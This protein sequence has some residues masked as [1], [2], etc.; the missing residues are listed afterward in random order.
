MNKPIPFFC[1]ILFI[2]T[3]FTLSGQSL[4]LPISM[5]V[6]GVEIKGSLLLADSTI[7]TPVVLIIA[8]SGPTDRDGNNVMMKNN[9]LKFLAEGLLVHG[10][11]SVRYDKRGVAESM[12]KGMKEEDLRFDHYVDDVAAWVDKLNNDHRFSEVIIVGHSEGSLIGMIAAQKS[13]PKRFIS[14]AGAGDRAG[15]ALKRQLKVQPPLFYEQCAAIIDTLEQGQL[16]EKVSPLYYSLFRPSVQPYLISYFKYDP[17]K[18]ISK[19]K[20]P[21]LIVQG[22]TDIQVKVEDAQKLHASKTDAILVII[23]K[24]NH[25]F[26]E[27]PLDR[28]ENILTYNNPDLPVIPELIEEIYSFISENGR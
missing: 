18:E 11:S 19:L 14:L 20:I 5:D 8:G 27:S 26:K 4:D 23:E 16:V 12:M 6:E 21:T 1:L 22:T 2:G 17:Q 13:N 25:L 9:S 3:T 24:M 10:I 7:Q 15:V 28:Q